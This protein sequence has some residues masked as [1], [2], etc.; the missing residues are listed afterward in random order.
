MLA[1][2]LQEK[3]DVAIGG[4]SIKGSTDTAPSNMISLRFYTHDPAICIR[5]PRDVKRYELPKPEDVPND[6]E[7]RIKAGVLQPTLAKTKSSPAKKTDKSTKVQRQVPSYDK[8]VE[9]VA[10]APG[11]DK[12]DGHYKRMVDATWRD[13]IEGQTPT[14]DRIDAYT[15]A[16]GDKHD[17]AD[18]VRAV[19]GAVL[20]Y[21]KE[22]QT[23]AL[24][25]SKRPSRLFPA[26]TTMPKAECEYDLGIN[27]NKALP[28]DKVLYVPEQH[29]W[30]IWEGN[31]WRDGTLELISWMGCVGKNTFGVYKENRQGKMEFKKQKA[32][33]GRS[34]T[35]KN[36]LLFLRRRERDR[37]SVLWDDNRRV[38]GIP[39]GDC[40]EITGDGANVRRQRTTDYI[41]QTLPFQPADDWRGGDFEE[42]LNF[43][44]P[45]EDTRQYLQRH[46]GYGLICDGSEPYFLWLRGQGRSGKSTLL[47]FIQSCIPQHF[48]AV[49]RDTLLLKS[50]SRHST[51]EAKLA[52]KRIAYWAEARDDGNVDAEKIKGYTGGD[53]QTSYFM[54]Q[55]TF[56]WTPRFLLVIVSNGDLQLAN[57]DDAFYERVRL[58]DCWTTIP[59]EERKT[60]VWR[61]ARSGDRQ[62]LRWLADGAADYV[63]M[64]NDG[65]GSGLLPE[66]KQ[67]LH[68][69]LEWQYDTDTVGKFVEEQCRIISRPMTSTEVSS[70][71]VLHM[72]YTAWMQ[73]KTFA[74]TTE[75]EPVSQ[76]AMSRRLKQLPGVAY[77]QRR[78]GNSDL[79]HRGF[80]IVTKD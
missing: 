16:V 68:D 33:G 78:F 41:T 70:I 56:D 37:S 54:R 18:V 48:T 8:R 29:I 79:R 64:L 74:D 61:K 9:W 27:A 62:C 11:N 57:P 67:M 39:N 28:L 26:T 77:K 46:F 75:Q 24:G 5:D 80:N 10:E 14:E 20:K 63:R 43:V 76:Q 55:D 72:S 1:A 40:L 30:R 36:S 52:N 60:S 65:N 22:R 44:V 25:K 35:A 12:G 2:E 32:T 17:R 51:T 13:V 34:S 45:D 38:L 69:R 50:A 47:R 15:N 49:Q 4:M 58:V 21:N 3:Y 71:S 6:K 31:A 7:S 42:F 19:E 73:Q 23:K 66:T 59:A 53:E